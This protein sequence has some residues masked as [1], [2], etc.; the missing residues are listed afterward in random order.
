[1]IECYHAVIEDPDGITYTQEYA[2][3][4]DLLDLKMMLGPDYWI[5]DIY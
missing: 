1:M 4:D 3:F 5:V 2:D